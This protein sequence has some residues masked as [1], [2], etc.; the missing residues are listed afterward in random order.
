MFLKLQQIL[1][2]FQQPQ[3]PQSP[4]IDNTVMAQ[5][6]AITAQLKTTSAQPP[7]QKA[8]FP[9]PEQKTSFDKVS[10]RFFFVF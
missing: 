5:V 9:P 3:K 6:Q 8:T 4:V 7:E 10:L 2:T 1:Q